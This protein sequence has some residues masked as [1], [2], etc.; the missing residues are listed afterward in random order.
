MDY[1][2]ELF[3]EK[4]QNYLKKLNDFSYVEGFDLFNLVH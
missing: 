4:L 2:D 3:E 1:W